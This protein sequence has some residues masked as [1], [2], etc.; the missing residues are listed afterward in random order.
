MGMKDKLNEELK[1]RETEI[2]NA[3]AN[4]IHCV[5]FDQGLHGEIKYR[6]GNI[7]DTPFNIL[8]I[9]DENGKEIKTEN[10]Y[11]YEGNAVAIKLSDGQLGSFAKMFLE[12][13]GAE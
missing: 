3:N 1:D 9:Y 7:P 10:G 2:F 8:I 13:I 12:F 5:G 11:Q 4:E 6:I